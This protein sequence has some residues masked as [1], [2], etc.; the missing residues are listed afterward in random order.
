MSKILSK[1]GKKKKRIAGKKNRWKKKQN[2]LRPIHNYIQLSSIA[3][4]KMHL[5]IQYTQQYTMLYFYSLQRKKKQKDI[6]RYLASTIVPYFT[7]TV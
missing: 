3:F 4:Q 1:I 7:P 2:R 6:A 5:L